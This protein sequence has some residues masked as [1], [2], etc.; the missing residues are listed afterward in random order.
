MMALTIIMDAEFL[1]DSCFATEPILD[2]VLF[3]SWSKIVQTIPPPEKEGFR[4]NQLTTKRA[5]R[6]GL[7]NRQE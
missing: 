2:S 7:D 3:A 6:P 1:A 4:Y 5:S